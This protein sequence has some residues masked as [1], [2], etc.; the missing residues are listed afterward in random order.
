[1]S[2]TRLYRNWLGMLSRCE[3]PKSPV[4]HNYGGRGISVCKRW[5]DF[6]KFRDDMGAGWRRGLS[7]ER[8]NV[9]GNYEPSN[10][11]WATFDE[12]Q[13]NKRS[14]IMVETPWG[15][16]PLG[17]AALKAGLTNQKVHWRYSR[18]WTVEEALGLVPRKKGNPP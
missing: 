10:C 15:I 16:L 3:N 6:E 5:H 4:F 1:M 11:R 2:K 7:L 17:T 9:D 14:N 12:Q 13:R 18:G 8:V